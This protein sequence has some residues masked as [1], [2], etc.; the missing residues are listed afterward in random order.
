VR[1]PEHWWPPARRGVLTVDLDRKGLSVTTHEG[2]QERASTAEHRED[3][4]RRLLTAGLSPELLR[5]LVPEFTSLIDDLAE[6]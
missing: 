1:E 6:A 5:A 2:T 3:V 4:V